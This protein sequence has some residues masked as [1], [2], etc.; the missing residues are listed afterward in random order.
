MGQSPTSR[1]A[2]RTIALFEAIKG[3]LVLLA[4]AGALS[5]IH[6]DVQH[7]AETLVLHLH[8]NPAHHS[9]RIFLDFAARVTDARLA[10]L[11]ALAAGYSLLRFVEAYGL[12]RERRWAEWLAA[13]SG[14]VYIPF[15]IANLFRG[16]FWLPLAALAVN[17]VVVGIMVQALMRRALAPAPLP[18]APGAPRG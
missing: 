7:F 5:L 10:S 3:A 1:A 11:A 9:P 18:A 4:G 12:A 15:E 2:I 8:L 13:V 17:L 16:E 14:A 6:R